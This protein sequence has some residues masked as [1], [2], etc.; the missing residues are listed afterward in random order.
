VQELEGP[1]QLDLQPDCLEPGAQVAGPEG[2]LVR[3]HVSGPADHLERALG[4]DLRVEE[5]RLAERESPAQSQVLEGPCEARVEVDVVQDADPDDRVELASLEALSGLDVPDHD[6][7]AVADPLSGDGGGGLAQLDRD[8]LAA[9]LEQPG[10]ELARAA[11]ELEAA[12]A[13]TEVRLLDQELRSPL[14]AQQTRAAGP[15]P[16]ALLAGGDQLALP[17]LVVVPLAYFG[18]RPCASAYLSAASVIGSRRYG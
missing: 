16:D 12:D 4:P 6:L 13:G 5:V 18:S 2:G 9:T 3:G 10:G 17:A 1:A 8:E 11:A 15:A 14:C 7:R